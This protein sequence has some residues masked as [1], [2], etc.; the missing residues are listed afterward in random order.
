MSL[1]TGRLGELL[2]RSHAMELAGSL[3][4]WGIPVH[5][6]PE[7]E[8]KH[9]TYLTSNLYTRRGSGL[10]FSHVPTRRAAGADFYPEAFSWRRRS[11]RTAE[12]S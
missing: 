4:I 1:T 10:D 12:S 6:L 8:K 2:S 9:T 5:H 11:S 3:S 7:E